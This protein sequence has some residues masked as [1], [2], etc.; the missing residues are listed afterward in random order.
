VQKKKAR[1]EL[2]TYIRERFTWEKT[3]RDTLEAYEQVLADDVNRK[4]RKL[5]YPDL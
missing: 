4:Q 3:A 2:K 1:I 5:L